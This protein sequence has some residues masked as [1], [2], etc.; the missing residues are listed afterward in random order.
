MRMRH[1]FS[2]APPRVEAAATA[3]ASTVG[4][5]TRAAGAAGAA[6]RLLRLLRTREW[7]WSAQLLNL[8]ASQAT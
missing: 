4:E 2:L 7:W 5:P 3:V 8:R 1:V 6:P